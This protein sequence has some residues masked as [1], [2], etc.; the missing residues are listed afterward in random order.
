MPEPVRRD[1]S[2]Q[3]ISGIFASPSRHRSV[4]LRIEDRQRRWF[5]GIR[6]ASTK[7]CIDLRAC[8][9]LC[10]ASRSRVGSE[11]AD[12]PGAGFSCSRGP[13]WSQT[14][15]CTR[16]VTTISMDCNWRCLAQGRS[17]RFGQAARG[18]R[19]SAAA[20]CPEG[21]GARQ[22]SSEAPIPLS[23]WIRSL[24][25]A[26]GDRSPVSTRRGRVPVSGCKGAGS[27]VIPT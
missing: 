7:K 18:G 13:H 3:R 26:G 5:G 12:I 6:G 24:G 8:S 20:T 15:A 9:S 23:Q 4:K 22:L 27:S 19:S 1:R 2:E 10:R 11:P 16:T 17:P 21:A 14:R 25:P